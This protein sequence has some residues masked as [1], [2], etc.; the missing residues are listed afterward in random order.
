MTALSKND[1]AMRRK[2]K[3]KKPMFFKK[4]AF[5]ISLGYNRMRSVLLL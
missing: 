1:P 5:E 4:L 2:S 3:E